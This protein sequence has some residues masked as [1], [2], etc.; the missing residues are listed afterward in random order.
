MVAPAANPTILFSKIKNSN[1]AMTFKEGKKRIHVWL[2]INYFVLA[3]R[4]NN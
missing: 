2:D 3:S 4:K 1:V